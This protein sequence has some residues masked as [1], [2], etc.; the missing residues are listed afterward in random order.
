MNRF[1][2]IVDLQTQPGNQAEF[3]AL[4]SQ[5]AGDS[6]SY[7]TGCLQFDVLVDPQDP[8]RITFYEVYDSEAAFEKHQQSPHFK[9]YLEHAVP[10]L[11]R[12]ERRFLTR[13][14]P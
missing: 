12:R 13:L 10:L 5:N 11:K 3:L 14:D 2:L 8:T 6:L 9:H 1:V 4:A 7:E